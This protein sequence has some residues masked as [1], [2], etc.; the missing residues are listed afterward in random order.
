VL[1]LRCASQVLALLLRH[2]DCPPQREYFFVSP[3][4]ELCAHTRRCAPAFF[5]RRYRELAGVR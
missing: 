1:Q 5:S 3:L 4:V 2:A